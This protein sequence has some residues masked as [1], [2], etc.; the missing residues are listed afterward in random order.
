[1]PQIQINLR[2]D[3]D[4]RNSSEAIFSRLGIGL[5]TAINMYLHAVVRTGGITFLPLGITDDQLPIIS[6]V[7]VNDEQINPSEFSN[8]KC[9]D[10]SLELK[11]VGKEC[12]EDVLR[13]A[14]GDDINLR[15]FFS[16]EQIT[17]ITNKNFQGPLG[18]CL[19]DNHESFGLSYIRGTKPCRYKYIN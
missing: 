1:M 9:P 13:R 3:S 17:D 10:Y 2:M 19:Y 8:W 11:R 7:N 15:H 6:T 5:T 14:N 12:I 18:N 16:V 4:L